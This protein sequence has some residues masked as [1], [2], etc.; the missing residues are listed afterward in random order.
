VRKFLYIFMFLPSVAF[1]NDIYISQAGDTL[2]LDITQD[3]SGNVIGTS[4]QDVV[5]GSAAV[6]SDDMTFSITQTGNTNTIAA[7]IYGTS[8]TGT[9]VFTGNS[10]NVDLLCDSAATSGGGNCDTVT[11]NIT[12]TG[13]NNTFDFKIGETNDAADATINFTVDGDYNLVDMDL[14][15]TDA[16]ITVV[17]DNSASTGTGSTISSINDASL[18]TSSPGNIIDLAISG[19]G[20]SLGHTV[21]LDI[22]GGGSV[23]TITQ[24]GVNDNL[25]DITSTGDDNTVDITQSD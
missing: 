24:S 20:D 13:D 3:G 22:T 6:A 1:A 21:T 17:I 7:Q 2:D 4:S 11:L 23:Y 14:D 25:V 15:G 12:T 9:W 19:N 18:T 8:Y 10:N 5:L 16:N